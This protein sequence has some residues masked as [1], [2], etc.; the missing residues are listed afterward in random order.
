MR[1]EECAAGLKEVGQNSGCSPP[2]AKLIQ[3]DIDGSVLMAMDQR[4]SPLCGENTVIVQTISF[5]RAS[6][7]DKAI[8][9]ESFNSC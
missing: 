6:T 9:P 7:G 3:I 4:V 2:G 8:Q 5:G 1:N